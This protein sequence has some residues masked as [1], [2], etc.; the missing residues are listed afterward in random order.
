MPNAT[1][2][3]LIDESSLDDVM[4]TSEVPVLVYV[5]A[6]WCGP[7]QYLGPHLEQV[8]ADLGD[9]LHVVKIDFDRSPQTQEKYGISGIPLL[10]L[11]TGGELV[12][13]LVGGRD[14]DEMKTQ[15]RPLLEVRSTGESAAV[16]PR[17]DDSPHHVPSDWTPRGPRVLTFPD[18]LPGQLAIFDGWIIDRG[19]S[20]VVPAQGT[21]EV[22]E[23]RVVWLLVQQPGNKENPDAPADPVDLGF[24]R[25]LPADGIDKLVVMAPAISAAGLADVAH[26]TGL[27][28]LSVNAQALVGSTAEAA[29]AL[30]G[31]TQLDEVHLTIPEADDA[32]VTQVAGLSQLKELWVT[33]A[34]VTDSGMVQLAR[35]RGLRSLML[36]T[37]SVSDT[38]LA[39]LLK[40]D[41]PELTTL[42]LGVP[43]TTDEGLVHL[44]KLTSL[45]SLHITAPKATPAG[46]RRLAGLSGLTSLSF[47]DTPVDDEVVDALAALTELR[48]LGLVGEA[49]VSE[50]AY[51]RLRG[52]LPSVKINGVWVAPS[53]V[54]HALN[55]D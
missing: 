15:L 37:P 11:F 40:A 27:T 43:E 21:V 41:L 1:A 25:R 2:I 3:P 9:S 31:L 30:A 51:L 34:G 22:A 46:L 23:D 28:R 19:G 24:L 44:A 35:A 50:T 39:G 20:E 13:R 5:W 55:A 47:D 42:M 52:A 18:G 17:D 54:R 12:A 8:A 48:S 14:A 45:K 4:R 10:L 38:G 16:T 6:E 26:L 29:A 49:N 36:N 32:F 7:C 53:A 33:A